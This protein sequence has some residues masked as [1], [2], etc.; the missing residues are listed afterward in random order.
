MRRALDHVERLQHGQE[1]VRVGRCRRAAAHLAPVDLLAQRAGDEQRPREVQRVLVE[2]GELGHDD[3]VEV[4]HGQRDRL[5]GEHL[6]A[7]Q[8]RV[9]ALRPLNSKIRS[10]ST[11]PS[12]ALASHPSGG[13]SG[14]MPASTSACSPRSLSALRTAKSRSL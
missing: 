8:Q 2:R 6:G 3:V 10:T 12:H 5:D 9:D 13:R 14:R 7:V 11:S 4:Q 1:A